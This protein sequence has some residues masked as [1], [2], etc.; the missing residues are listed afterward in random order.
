MKLYGG[1]NL[2][3]NGVTNSLRAMHLQTEILGI[4]NKNVIGFDKIGYQRQDPVVSSFCEY[5]GVHG[6]SSTID[7]KIGRISVSENPLDLAIAEKG[8]FQILTPNGIKLSRDGRFRYDKEGNFQSLDGSKVLSNAGVPIKLP[9]IPE[10]VDGVKVDKNG[11]LSVFN[12]KT[13]KLEYVATVGVVS[14]TGVAVLEPN[15]KQGFNEYSNVS[16]AQEFLE[17][18][19]IKRNFEA[20]RELFIIQNSNLTKVLSELGKA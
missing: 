15:I 19:P 20:N 14:S 10:S 6:L 5:L 13:G 3:E 1:I 2:I 17:M 11:N 8:Y 9:F 4:A 16:L 18:L 12:K 7:D